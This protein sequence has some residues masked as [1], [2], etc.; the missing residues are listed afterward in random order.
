MKL[1]ILIDQDRH[2]RL[3]DFGLLTIISDHTHF[4]ASSSASTSGTTRWMS[5]EL[6]HPEQFGSDH[7]RPTKESD[8]YALG[9][10]I[11]EVLTG[12]P[13]FTPLKEHIVTQKVTSGE[14]P[15]R[16]EG[17]KG[18]WFTDDLWE[19]LGL[20][21]ARDAQSRPSI[22]AVR[23]CLGQVSGTW[24]P[25]HPRAD[26]GSEDEDDWNLT[27][28]T[29]WIFD[30]ISFAHVLVEEPVLIA[31][32]IRRQKFGPKDQL[33]PEPEVSPSPQPPHPLLVPEPNPEPQ[34]QG[35]T[36]AALY[37][38][39]FSTHQHMAPGQLTAYNVV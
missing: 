39:V 37:G 33:E 31:P 19:M 1:N 30:L 13:P 17:L 12:R 28:L 11:L 4:T 6:L 9:M 3:A 10:V 20:C 8:C 15:A 21:W 34:D 5:P 18:I 35:V 29:V 23:E 25:L 22:D 24:K 32:T 26:Q 38:Y 2:A 16:P 7:G 36:T 27:L 14:R